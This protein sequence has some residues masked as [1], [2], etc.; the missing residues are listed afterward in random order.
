M[1]VAAKLYG[2][3][4]VGPLGPALQRQLAKEFVVPPL[5][6]LDARQ[7]FW[8]QRK[9]LWLKLGIKS[10]IGRAEGLI[11]YSP[12]AMLKSPKG[13]PGTSVFDP[14]LAELAY[15]W[16]C[17]AGG[18]VLDPFA[19][20]SVRGIVA[21]V[22]GLA[23]AGI[24]LRPEQVE[25]NRAQLTP[26]NTGPRPPKWV[27]ADAR[28]ALA[29]APAADF[30]FTCPPYGD[31]ERYSDDARDIST[32]D[33]PAF[34]AAMREIIRLAA[35]KL[36]Q[37]RFAAIVVGNFRDRK[38]GGLR[39]FTG[40]ICRAFELAGLQYYNDAVLCTIVSSASLRARRVFKS[41]RKLCRTHQNLLVFVKG[42]WRA[43][44]ALC[45]TENEE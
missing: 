16:W 42:S 19:G 9:K 12:R 15:R 17:P 5:T 3:G 36:R 30:I 41:G 31:L 40:D 28:E 10:E 8:Q 26:D 14:V 44:G 13:D 45:G 2:Q 21:S 37:D 22:L 27:C 11:G 29:K 43:A 7:G 35:A 4:L 34:M 25:A 6:M 23:Y 32:Y 1:D 20:G 33:Y 18:R 24:E 38:T 39:D